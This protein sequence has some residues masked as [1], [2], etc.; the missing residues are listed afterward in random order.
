MNKTIK[1]K[2]KNKNKNKKFNHLKC[3]PRTRKYDYT[4][5]SRNKLL[6][7]KELWNMRHPDSLIKSNSSK[8]IWSQLKNNLQDTCDN[9]SCWLKQNFSEN[10]I[11]KEKFKNIF[12]PF[13]PKSWNKNPNEWLSSIDINRVMKQYEH[14]Y[15][16]FEF[17]GPSPIDF[18]T[19][20]HDGRCVWEELCK[21]DYKKK[22]D[23]KKDYIGVIFNLD[24]HDAP[25]SHW[26]SLF[27][28]LRKSNIY[29]FDSVGDK[30]HV[31][32][33]TLVDRVQNQGKR[34]GKTIKYYVN[35]FEHQKG[36]S[37]CGVYSLYFIIEMLNGRDFSYFQDKRIPDKDIE[38]F[39]KIYFNTSI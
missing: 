23:K 28:D 36:N 19:H 27:M 13:S 12:R 38:K 20:F 30:P 37:E 32:I 15:S 7:L 26:V 6:R 34:E 25:G 5:F 24:P 31:N 1:N 18:D 2:N 4:C 16:N 22:I 17:I 14:S 33:N 3:A 8:Q 39:R 9:E 10:K 21:F 35:D 29:F 11:D